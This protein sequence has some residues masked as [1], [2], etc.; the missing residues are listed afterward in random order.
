MLQAIKL[1]DNS[2]SKKLFKETWVASIKRFFEYRP[3]VYCDV[4]SPSR[5][6]KSMF[7][8][9]FLIYTY[10]VL[11]HKSFLSRIRNINCA[12]TH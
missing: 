1:V 2:R 10:T 12:F 8:A 4:P 6:L 9:E 7:T 3:L 11:K 5:L